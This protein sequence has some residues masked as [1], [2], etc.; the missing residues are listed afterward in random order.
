MRYLTRLNGDTVLRIAAGLLVSGAYLPTA[1]AQQQPST[2]LSAKDRAAKFGLSDIRGI[3]YHPGPYLRGCAST[4][5]HKC[6][7]DT[8][9]PKPLPVD[10][11]FGNYPLPFFLDTIS[12]YDQNGKLFQVLAQRYTIYYDADFYNKD[13][14]AL[15][16]ARDSVTWRRDDLGR[17]RSELYANFVHLYDWN[18]DDP[19]K[20]DHGPFL[21]YAQRLSMHVTIPISNDTLRIMC[22]PPAERKTWENWVGR[23]VHITKDEELVRICKQDNCILGLIISGYRN[24]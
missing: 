4:V 12:T 22:T 1:T 16:G 9:S 7:D 19:R 3:A 6:T 10:A 2:N 11:K 18:P 8:G 15:W 20:R 17:F 24:Y 21:D 13:F 5:T 23:L 14:Q